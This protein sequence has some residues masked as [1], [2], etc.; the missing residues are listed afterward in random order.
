L[1]LAVQPLICML[2]Q[3]GASRRLASMVSMLAI[4]TGVA[5][6]FLAL[7]YGVNQLVTEWPEY[8]RAAKSVRNNV[9]TWLARHGF[10]QLAISV[11]ATSLDELVGTG[12]LSLL[13]EVPQLLGHTLFILVLAFFMIHEQRSFGRKMRAELGAPWPFAQ[14]IVSDVQHYLGVKTLV[15]TLTGLSAGLWCALWNV[16]NAPRWGVVA[17]VLNYIPVAG[18]IVAAIP[19]V[20][21]T[22]LT[23]SMVD[24]VAVTLGYLGLNLVFGYILEP[25]W[26]GKACGLSTLVVLVSMTIWGTILGPAGALLSVTLTCGIRHAMKAAPDLRWLGKFFEDG[27]ASQRA[28]APPPP[29]LRSS[30]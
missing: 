27:P 2:E 25:R 8:D 26:L 6:F 24:A 12:L 3:R 21:A 4:V 23:G 7:L 1:T 9:T 18:S 17:F 28:S 29:T 10:Q 19:A 11:H 15:S 5:V 14:R 22:V 30:R 16:P 13:R 20:A